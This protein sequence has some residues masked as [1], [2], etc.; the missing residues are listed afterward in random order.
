MERVIVFVP[1]E[2]IDLY[3][4][5]G[6][7]AQLDVEDLGPMTAERCSRKVVGFEFPRFRYRGISAT[8]G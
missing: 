3:Y 4:A 8:Q 5:N 2:T 6:D 1:S 7:G